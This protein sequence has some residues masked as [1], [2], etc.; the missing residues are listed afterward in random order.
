MTICSVFPCAK[1]SPADVIRVE[2]SGCC[3]TPRERVLVQG[4][5]IRKRGET[6]V[7]SADEG[8]RGAGSYRG[9]WGST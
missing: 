1:E 8:Q 9:P 5:P 3:S 2:S 4:D 6:L 7:F